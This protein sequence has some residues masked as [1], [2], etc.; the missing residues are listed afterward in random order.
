MQSLGAAAFTLSAP[1]SVSVEGLV[2]THVVGTLDWLHASQDVPCTLCRNY[3][4]YHTGENRHPQQ[5]HQLL[6]GGEKCSLCSNVG[7]RWSR[8]GRHPCARLEHRRRGQYNRGTGFE[9]YLGDLANKIRVNGLIKGISGASNQPPVVGQEIPAQTL[10]EGD[11]LILDIR[12]SF[13]DPDQQALDYTVESVD[14]S[15]ASAATDNREQTLTIRG[16]GR[17]RT[18]LTVTATDRH[19]ARASQTF[20][21]T[22]L[23]ST[24]VALVPS[25]SDP[26]DRQGFVRVINHSS[27]AGEVRIDAIDDEGESYGRWCWV[28]ALARRC[29]STPTTWRTATRRRGSLT[30]LARARA[31]GVWSSRAHWT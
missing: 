7:R 18:E 24:L 27:E 29:T 15:V 22:V 2:F 20:M 26:L 12:R 23:G 3:D 9:D 8:R 10:D 13:H 31:T 16:V 4:N 19:D 25:A 6:G 17:G 21:A 14:P 1:M 5:E 11:E 28:S 30:A